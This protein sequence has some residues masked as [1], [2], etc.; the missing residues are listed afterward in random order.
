MF[1]CVQP[2]D[3]K[4]FQNLYSH[5]VNSP[6]NFLQQRDL[7]SFSRCTT[8]RFPTFFLLYTTMRFT[9][10]QNIYSHKVNSLFNLV[11]S[12]QQQDFQPFSQ[13]TTTR[14]TALF[15]IFRHAIYNLFLLYTAKNFT[16]FLSTR[17][18]GSYPV[19]LI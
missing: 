11:Y 10:F 17:L 8:T 2:H 3:L 4:S 1:L 12:L 5:K 15:T 16:T 7:Q 9:I 18:P 6:L 19:V 13:Y 14:F